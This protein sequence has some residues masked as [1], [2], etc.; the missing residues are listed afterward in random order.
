M[1]DHNDSESEFFSEMESIYG[2]GA[3]YVTDASALLDGLNDEQRAAVTHLNGPLLILAGAGSGKTRVITYRIAYMMR[4]HNV[5]PSSILAI[6]FTNKAA[7]EMRERIEALVGDEARYIWCGTFHSI[8]AKLLRRH[9]ESIG[10]TS[11]FMIVDSDDQLKLIRDSMKELGIPESRFKPRAILSEISK[12]KNKLMNVDS[13]TRFAGGDYFL[14]SCAKVY[15]RYME[16]LSANNAMDFD[17]ILVNM[18]RLLKNDPEILSSYQDRFRYIMVDEYQD[19]NTP[20]YEAVML[21]AGM[22]KN[23]CVVGDDDQ[24]IYSF[25]GADVKLILSFEKDFPGCKVIKLEENYRSTQTILDAA[26]CVI[27]HNTKRKSKTLRTSGSKGDRIIL[28][29]SDSGQD[30]ARFV[31]QTIKMVVVKGKFSY[32]DCAVLYRMNALSRSLEST[33]SSFGIPFKVYGGLRF[34][35]RKEIKDILCYLRLINDTSDN[36]SFERV[37]NVPKR[38]IGDTTVDKIRQISIDQGIDMFTVARNADSYPDLARSANRL[39][40]FTELIER[41]RDALITGDM[42]FMHFV[43]YVENESGVIDEIVEQREKKG[44]IVDRVENL[45]ELLSEAAEFDK[46]H[47]GEPSEGGDEFIDTSTADT[48]EG[49]LRIYLENAALVTEGDNFDET[50]DFVKLMTIHSAKGLE[51]GAVFLVGCEEGVFPGYRAMESESEIE[52]ER[53]LMYVAITRAKKNLFIVLARQRLLF[54]NTQCNRPSRFISEIN[55]ELLYPMGRE[56]KIEKTEDVSPRREESRKTISASLASQFDRKPKKVEGALT[57][58]EVTEGMMVSHPRFGE[59]KVLRVEMAGGDALVTIDF[60]GMRKNMLV[61]SSG[62]KR[63]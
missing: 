39:F 32:K 53:R 55:K 9:A 63:V 4:Q 35:D 17:D 28:M 13:F 1:A 21:L 56:R 60:D 54:G 16:K 51:F 5:R 12:A 47:R 10:F 11:N 49:I 30:E 8:F 37:I 34:Y 59:G 2:A 62:L 3:S 33:L 31:A 7:N 15:K 40:D 43:D 25:R 19:T 44:E 50:D 14:S 18:V 29:N 46:E 45:K 57:A 6:T 38:G 22:H 61:N 23:I 52:E 42:D 48:T 58:D 20:Q 27:A 24:S 41:M 36:I 26:N